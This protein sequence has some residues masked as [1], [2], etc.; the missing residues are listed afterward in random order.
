DAEKV[1]LLKGIIKFPPDQIGQILEDAQPLFALANKNMDQAI[2]LT[3]KQGILR[4]VGKMDPNGRKEFI[5]ALK[6]L[7]QGIQTRDPLIQITL[8]SALLKGLT[9]FPA[10]SRVLALRHA[11]PLLQ[12][13]RNVYGM[14]EVL[15][16]IR[17]L[18][19]DEMED[20]LAKAEPIVQGVTDTQAIKDI[21]QAVKEMPAD[22]RESIV[23]TALSLLQDGAH[24]GVRA[25]L[26][27]LLAQLN[28]ERRTSV[29]EACAPFLNHFQDP[30]DRL[31][32]L[33]AFLYVSPGTSLDNALAV[34]NQGG[35]ASQ[36]ANALRSSSDAEFRLNAR[37]E[38]GIYRVVLPREQIK[39]NPLALLAKL[40]ENIDKHKIKQLS[41]EFAGEEG[42]DASGLGREF[43]SLLSEAVVEALR[44]TPQKNG[45]VRAIPMNEDNKQICQQLGKLMMFCLNSTQ[46]Y[47]M[48]MIFD[49]GFFAML[50]M[51][52]P[53][54]GSRAL[55]DLLKDNKT[56][57]ELFTIYL[58]MES[59]NEKEADTIARLKSWNTPFNQNTDPAVLSDLYFSE[60]CMFEERGGLDKLSEEEIKA[61]PSILKQ[62][63]Y[64]AALQE[65]AREKI[66]ETIMA[67]LQPVL[68]A[69]IE[70]AKG[71]QSVN[72]PVNFDKAQKMGPAALS[73]KL[74][75]T[76]STPV[77]LQN[78][79]F[80]EDI[81]PEKQNLFKEWIETLPPD[82]LKRFVF[83]LTGAYAVGKAEL[84]LFPTSERVIFHTC[85]SYADIPF[86]AMKSKED[87]TMVMAAALTG[88]ESFNIG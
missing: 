24:D 2:R 53:H 9:K 33:R 39:Q 18:P 1:A 21:I 32:I 85:F 64:M 47:P 52:Q 13:C 30:S 72:Y 3:E 42:I 29:L 17:R 22:E 41:I 88:E 4:Q 20:I 87:I 11:V 37:L 75:G 7:W 40:T 15:A 31:M 54:H 5:E 51:L 14:V 61:D 84:K 6:P 73:E 48:G 12:N 60:S 49:H 43:V 36:I 78:L 71:M 34:L 57:N 44:P 80:S 81:P 63:E 26:L 83:A 65:V 70:V 55:Q 46:N 79:K 62:P 38:Q 16:I 8:R 19:T 59:T 66:A 23:G 82:Q 56:F 69:A 50:S 76:L 77:V 25:Q 28:P 67:A 86:N 68:P 10:E 35:S 27:Q 58:A 74:Q 45:L